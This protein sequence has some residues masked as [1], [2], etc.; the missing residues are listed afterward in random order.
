MAAKGKYNEENIRFIEEAIK[1]YG[2]D[3]AGY[4]AVPISQDTFYRWI[5]EKPEFSERVANAR[6]FWRQSQGSE[7]KIQAWDV[8]KQYL[9]GGQVEHWTVVKDVFDKDGKIVQLTE[10]RTVRRQTPQWV[11]ERYLGKVLHE[12]E[13]IQALSN[14]LPQWAI[15]FA[16]N[17]VNHSTEEI[18][19]AF[20]GALP[21]R[22]IVGRDGISDETAALIRSKILGVDAADT[23]AVSKQVGERPLSGQ[24]D[25]EIQTD[26]S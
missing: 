25:S 8:V 19:K 11:L 17:E 22:S 7:A 1:L 23:A 18:R 14:W 20:T 26:R 4:E 6:Q 13:A 24:A 16:A 9:F 12:I 10:T 3:R 15:Q 21:D 5:K 2:T